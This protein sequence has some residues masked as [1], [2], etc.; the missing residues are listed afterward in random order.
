MNSRNANPETR[1]RPLSSDDLEVVIRI[2]SS[3]AGRP[4]RRFLEKRFAAASVRPGDFIHLG[5]VSGEA[6]VGFALIRI[7]RGEFGGDAPVASLDVLGVDPAPT[8]RG[9]GRSLL[10]GIASALSDTGIGILRSQA[11]WKNSDL[12]QFFETAGFAL[13]PRLILERSTALPFY[14]SFDD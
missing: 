9:Y 11:E 7:L 6:L 12:L 3:H 8:G 14:D 1:I 13:A 5:I 4:R 2:D 10:Q